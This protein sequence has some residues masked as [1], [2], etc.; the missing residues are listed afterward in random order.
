MDKKID[1]QEVAEELS[2]KSDLAPG[3]AEAFVQ[4]FF[5]VVEEGLETDKFVKIRGWGTFKI[6]AVSERESINVNTGARIQ[7]GSHNKVTFTPDGALKEAINKP[8]SQF[9]TVVVNDGT[10]LSLLEVVDTWETDTNESEVDGAPPAA[11]EAGISERA[12]E[13]DAG[14]AP[15]VPVTPPSPA[16]QEPAASPVAHEETIA[17]KAEATEIPNIPPR[18]PAEAMPREDRKG[19]EPA[20][21]SLAAGEVGQSEPR[22]SA[23]AGREPEGP[24]RT[25]GVQAPQATAPVNT[26]ANGPAIQYVI[27][28]VVRPGRLNVWKVVALVL[29]CIL[30]ISL[31]YCAGYHHMLC[32]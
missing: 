24:N 14:T 9:Q 15:D 28:E 13:P 1:L 3:V 12:E 4:T 31:S 23:L 32:P 25:E 10:D 11:L 30:L 29:V 17:P 21:A 2:R 6:I 19:A 27:K 8:F 22:P 5:D 20:E 16:L 18:I 26:T 7:I